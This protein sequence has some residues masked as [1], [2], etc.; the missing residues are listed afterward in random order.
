LIVGVDPAPSHLTPPRLPGVP[1]RDLA[2]LP[3]PWSSVGQ[4]LPVMDAV[5]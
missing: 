3:Q 2:A 1:G 5:S 4:V